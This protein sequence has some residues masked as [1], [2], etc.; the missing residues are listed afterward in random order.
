[1]MRRFCPRCRVAWSNNLDS[2]EGCWFCGDEGFPC[3]GSDHALKRHTEPS[4][5]ARLRD[6]Q[7]VEHLLRR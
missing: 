4:S 3:D 1:M 2:R 6:T 5:A 7:S